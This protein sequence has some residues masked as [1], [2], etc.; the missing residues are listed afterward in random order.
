MALW[1]SGFARMLVAAFLS[2]LVS[3]RMKKHRRHLLTGFLKQEEEGEMLPHGLMA[4]RCNHR[5]CA[6]P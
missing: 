3:S 1:V 5:R 6:R 2:V 4:M